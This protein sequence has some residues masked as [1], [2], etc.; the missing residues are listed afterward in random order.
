AWAPVRARLQPATLVTTSSGHAVPALGAGCG[1]YLDGRS[2]FGSGFGLLL[3]SVGLGDAFPPSL[4]AAAPARAG[5]SAPRC[6]CCPEA[7]C[8]ASPSGP[9]HRL[10]PTGAPGDEQPRRGGRATFAAALPCGGC[11]GLDAL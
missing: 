3:L 9:G 1:A 10:C 4:W 7:C 8:D 11:S 6:A 2:H 5:V